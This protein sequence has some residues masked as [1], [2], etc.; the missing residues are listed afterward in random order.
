M[1]KVS[2][3]N[4]DLTFTSKLWQAADKMR[5]NMDAAGF[6]KSVELDEIRKNGHILTPGRYVGT[7]ET[8]EDTEVFEDKMKRLTSEL[9]SSQISSKQRSKRISEN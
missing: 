8:E 3:D 6:S 2:N 7:A 4:G 5:N 9:S 1:P